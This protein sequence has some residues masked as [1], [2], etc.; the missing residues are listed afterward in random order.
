MN[1]AQ[2]K[3]HAGWTM[4]PFQFVLALGSQLRQD[5][6]LFSMIALFSMMLEQPQENTQMFLVFHT[7]SVFPTAG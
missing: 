7:H 5:T 6:S 1:D 2:R 4:P 3:A